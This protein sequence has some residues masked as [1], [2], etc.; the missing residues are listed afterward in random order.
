MTIFLKGIL[1]IPFTVTYYFAG[2]DAVINKAPDDCTPEDSKEVDYKLNLDSLT[3]ENMI[4]LI[5]HLI[6]DEED[7]ITEQ[8]LEAI[9]NEQGE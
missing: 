2:K 5:N 8:V 9:K 7:N 3:R 1:E 4:E 6:D